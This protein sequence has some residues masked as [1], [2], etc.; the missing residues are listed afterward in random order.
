MRLFVAEDEAPALARLVE[1]VRQ[2]APA[3]QVVGSAGSLRQARAWLASHPAPDLLL[4]DIQLA[5]GLSLELFADGALEVPTIFVTAYDEFVVQAFQAQAVDY[6][7]KPVDEGKLARAFERYARGRRA[8]GT[9]H[10]GALGAALRAERGLRQ[11][12]I[13]RAGS[14][15]VVLAVGSIACFVSLDKRV[16]AVGFDGQRHAVE[17]TLAELEAQLDAGR[18]FR[19]NRQVIVAVDAIESF[20]PSGKGGWVLELKAKSAGPVPVS[21]DRAADFK[22]WLSR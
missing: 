12:L 8:F 15:H 11:R 5:D 19:V 20:A 1:S 3:A 17:P 21:Q 18:F 22:A 9:H 6:L 2:V 16:F 4:L 13:G 7:L 10:A 14:D